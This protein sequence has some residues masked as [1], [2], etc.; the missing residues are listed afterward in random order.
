MSERPAVLHPV[1][2]Q[3][4]TSYCSSDYYLVMI[5]E[6]A[7]KTASTGRT[8]NWL[9]SSTFTHPDRWHYST[10]WKHRSSQGSWNTDRWTPQWKLNQVI[11]YKQFNFWWAGHKEE[12]S[13]CQHLNI[14]AE[15]MHANTQ[16]CFCI[17]KI[18][19]YSYFRPIIWPS[20]KI[21]LILLPCIRLFIKVALHL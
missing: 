12:I 1:P 7:V 16:C 5:S 8:G 6:G 19:W 18:N 2:S 21:K 4:L 3:Y 20:I 9:G 17:H 14:E 15:L 11:V 13:W 10:W